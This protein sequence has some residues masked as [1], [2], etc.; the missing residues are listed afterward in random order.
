[1]WLIILTLLKK[2][3]VKYWILGGLVI[4]LS[5]GFGIEE[6]RIHSL[7]KDL[8]ALATKLV[9]TQGK[10]AVMTSNRDLLK[11]VLKRQNAA[12]DALQEN[13]KAAGIVDAG[14]AANVLREAEKRQAA[15]EAD[16]TSGAVRMNVFLE[17]EFSNE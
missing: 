3:P 7:N 5:I 11:E 15:D 8:S 9:D 6:Y 14:E 10:L 16:K 2:V 4:A 17:K 12:V 1:M 13:A